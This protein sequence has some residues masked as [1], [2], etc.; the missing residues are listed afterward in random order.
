MRKTL[1]LILAMTFLPAVAQAQPRTTVKGRVSTKITAFCA[2]KL[3]TTS[4]RA[5]CELIQHDA[6]EEIAARRASLLGTSS[7]DA[8]VEKCVAIASADI[9][10]TRTRLADYSVQNACEKAAVATLASKARANA[11]PTTTTAED[12]PFRGR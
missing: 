9:A 11:A 6:L 5:K 1:I 7:G 3:A 8:I 10:A 12:N 4:M 2:R